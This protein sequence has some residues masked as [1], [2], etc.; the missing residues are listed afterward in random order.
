MHCATAINFQFKGLSR[1][2]DLAFD[3]MDGQFKTTRPVLNFL[4][5]QLI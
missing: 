2:M 4:D 5:A 3:D 1:E